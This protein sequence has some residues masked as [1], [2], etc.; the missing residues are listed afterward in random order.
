MIRIL[1][2]FEPPGK[3]IELFPNYNGWASSAPPHIRTRASQL[4]LII[5]PLPERVP[6][7]TAF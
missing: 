5:L 2:A 4:S 6:S 3:T 1:K 7:A